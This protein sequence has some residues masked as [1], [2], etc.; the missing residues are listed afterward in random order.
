MW[1]CVCFE[2]FLSL[3]D[4]HRIAIFLV[5]SILLRPRRDGR[6]VEGAHLESVYTET[7]R[8]FESLSLR[9]FLGFI[10]GTAAIYLQDIWT[11]NNI[12]VQCGLILIILC[13]GEKK[14]SG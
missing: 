3:D 6:A 9:Q 1:F 2:K 8:G 5:P 7:Y 4:S 13:A 10:V 12:I 14:I 11:K